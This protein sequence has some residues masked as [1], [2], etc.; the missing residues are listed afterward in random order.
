MT[1]V[2][3]HLFPQEKPKDDGIYLVTTLEGEVD[4]DVFQLGDFNFYTSEVIAW[5]ELPE[6]YQPEVNND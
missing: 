5:A 2:D 4:T 1:H 6:P 3:W